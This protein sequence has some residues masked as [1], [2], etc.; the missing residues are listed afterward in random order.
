MRDLG[1]EKNSQQAFI[2][3][4]ILRD[5]FLSATWRIISTRAIGMC[6]CGY[7]TA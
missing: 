1:H 5:S 3:R 2:K 4:V 6:P 7:L